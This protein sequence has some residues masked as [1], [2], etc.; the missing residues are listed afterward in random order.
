MYQ[1]NKVQLKL[2]NSLVT[3]SGRQRQKKRKKKKKRK[4]REFNKVG[5]GE[6]SESY[7]EKT[8]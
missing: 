4:E 3:K 2:L 1:R 8:Y 5:G 6:L 7:Q